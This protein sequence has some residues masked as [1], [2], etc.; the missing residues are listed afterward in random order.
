MKAQI[1][2]MC[3]LAIV[4]ALTSACYSPPEAPLTV[5]ARVGDPA[6]VK[7]LVAQGANPNAPDGVNSWTPLQHAI[8]KHQ[9]AS[10]VALLDSGA[11]PNA[12][13]PHGVTPLMMAA[14]YGYTDMVQI[15]LKRGADPR[16]RDRDGSTALDFAITGVT[17]IDRFTLFDCQSDTIKVL[18]EA[19][20][21]PSKT[22]AK[23][24]RC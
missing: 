3:K 21:P 8:H 13:D 12:P 23:L 10:M 7:K 9:I 24:K 17:D 19:G 20:A 1:I 4:F 14:G 18:R 22:A 15:L 2:R 16:L 5:A 6:A 11:D